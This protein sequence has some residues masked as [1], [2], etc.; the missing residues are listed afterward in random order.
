M[1]VSVFY[2]YIHLYLMDSSTKENI[3]I[4]FPLPGTI[5]YHTSARGFSCAYFDE[6]KK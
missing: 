3:F 6:S 4:L 1:F 5:V 2:I